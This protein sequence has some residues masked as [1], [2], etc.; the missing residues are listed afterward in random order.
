MIKKK[1]LYTLLL[2]ASSWGHGWGMDEL[3][4]QEKKRLIF[5]RWVMKEF[6]EQASLTGLKDLSGVISEKEYGLSINKGITFKYPSPSAIKAEILKGVSLKN[7]SF[8]MVDNLSFIARDDSTDTEERLKALRSDLQSSPKKEQACDVSIRLIQFAVGSPTAPFDKRV[9][10]RMIF[11]NFYTL[12][13]SYHVRMTRDILDFSLMA[14]ATKY[15]IDMVKIDSCGGKTTVDNTGYSQV[16]INETQDI[17]YT[18]RK[19]NPSRR[20]AAT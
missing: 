17:E 20:Q 3:F 10:N 4:D 14:P 8:T 19:I 6:F 15:E 1:S 18:I 7:M 2:V 11:E 12:T 13:I 16:S 9:S 5:N